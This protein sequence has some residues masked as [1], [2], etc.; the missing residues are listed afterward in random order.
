MRWALIRAARAVIVQALLKKAHMS[1][2]D[3]P[4][5]ELRKFLIKRDNQDLT[6]ISAKRDETINPFSDDDLR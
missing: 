5:H 1:N 4:S 6:S 3:N 2:K